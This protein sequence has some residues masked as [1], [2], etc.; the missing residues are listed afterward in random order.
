[1]Y[2]VFGGSFG[3]RLLIRDVF[4]IIFQRTPPASCSDRL[5]KRVC[6]TKQMIWGGGG[7]L[8][9]HQLMCLSL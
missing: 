8:C 5:G 3:K 6:K 7:A 1:M 4:I 2:A 9:I